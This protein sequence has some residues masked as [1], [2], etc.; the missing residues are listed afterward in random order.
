MAKTQRFKNFQHRKRS[1]FAKIKATVK[2]IRRYS[3]VSVILRIFK[4]NSEENT[5]YNKLLQEKTF[6]GLKTSFAITY[7]SCKFAMYITV[8]NNNS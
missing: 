6:N 2:V 8:P 3:D 7:V 4:Y 1:Y 5:R